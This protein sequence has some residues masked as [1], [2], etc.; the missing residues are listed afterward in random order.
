MATYSLTATTLEDAANQMT[1]I[2]GRINTFLQELQ[3]GTMRAILEWESVA[4][5]EFDQQR[6]LWANGAKEMTQQAAVAQSHLSQI[7][8]EYAAAEAAGQKI[9]SR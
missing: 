1:A 6:N 8:Q 3:T 2:S 9:W 5:D 4:R 7:L